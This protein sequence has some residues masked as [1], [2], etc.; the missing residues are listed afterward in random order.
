MIGCFRVVLK[1]VLLKSR[2]VLSLGAILP[3]DLGYSGQLI[4]EIMA[5]GSIIA[6]VMYGA[7]EIAEREAQAEGSSNAQDGTGCSADHCL[8]R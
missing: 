4:V 8:C 2:G 1:D 3:P 6:D 7:R 5:I